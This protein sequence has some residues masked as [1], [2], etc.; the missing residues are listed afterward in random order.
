MGAAFAVSVFLN[1]V[2]AR[3]SNSVSSIESIKA[4]NRNFK[5]REMIH[6]TLK[7]GASASSQ[8]LNCNLLDKQIR[9]GRGCGRP[10]ALRGTAY[11]GP[12]LS[13][14]KEMLSSDTKL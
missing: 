3:V 4:E 10:A 7:A 8:E 13:I 12:C 6:G 14:R 11:R 5:S 9:N 1:E 2:V